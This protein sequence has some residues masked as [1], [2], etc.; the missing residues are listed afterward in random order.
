MFENSVLIGIF[1][2]EREAVGLTGG[3]RKLHN[4]R[5]LKFIAAL[6]NTLINSVRY[7]GRGV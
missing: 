5:D 4:V 6:H 1:D 7:S 3:Y 2:P